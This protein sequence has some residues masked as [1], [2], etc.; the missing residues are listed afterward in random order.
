MDN[1]QQ[2]NAELELGVEP[3]TPMTTQEANSDVS[4]AQNLS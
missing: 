3:N 4:Q 1:N 2:P